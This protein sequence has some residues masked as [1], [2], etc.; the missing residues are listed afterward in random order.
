MST[1]NYSDM[2][3]V[4]VEKEGYEL[5]SEYKNSHIKVKL[6]C[7]IGH[8]YNVKPYS[9]KQGSRC[10]KCSSQ[11]PIQAKEQFLE[12]LSEEGYELLSEY[13]GSLIKVKIKCPEGHEYMAV[14]SKFK[15]G[16]RCPKCSNKCPEQ[17][18]EQF[19]QLICSIEYKL[20][21]E[22]INNRT[23][24]LLKCDKG[25]E[26]Y[27]RPY[28]FKNGARC[29]KCAGKCPIQVKEQFIKLLE[30]EGYEL[31]SEYKNTST[32]VKLKCLKG[33]IWETIPSNFTGHDNRCPKCS[34]QCPI[35]AKKD[36]LDL[37]NKERYELLSE[38][39]NNKT[40]VEIKCFEG[41]IYNVKPN[42]FKNGLR[43]PKCS[44]MCP[45]QAKEQFMELLEK[46]GYELLS[47]YKNT[48]T[49]VKLKCSEDH[50]YSV[51]PNSFQ[52]GHRCPKCAGLC[53]IQAKEKFIQT[54]DQEG[55]ELI[56][57]YINITTKVKLKCPEDH[58]WNVIPSSF[59]YN[60]TRC[61]HC[62]GSTGQRLLQKMLKEYDIGNVI[63]ND[64]E[65]LNGLELDIYYPELNI[66]IEYQGNYWH[67]L[68]DHIERDKRKRE[69]C[70]ELNIKLLEIWDDDFMKD[71]V[72]EINKIIN[73]IQG[74]K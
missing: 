36:F 74:V 40:K 37:L 23:K 8:I 7:P 13:K 64:R 41:H 63:Y 4:F 68:P 62:A 44:N 45:I 35:Q 54:L 20:I 2:F 22:Y 55:Y 14:P 18:K 31:L 12:L 47:E 21:S 59:K 49:K 10:P 53:P 42:S 71:Q 9:F 24:V 60:Y 27:V 66:G 11:C 32:K 61:P 69:L 1:Q 52:Q 39:K 65:V 34:G 51:T 33:H 56:G 57:E 48:Q 3:A 29:P 46:E 26:Y 6:K 67:S 17:A 25:H 50:E 15:I 73:I 38:Y 43:C 19:L 28:S 58:E 70:K 5:L 16:D 72:T 30:S